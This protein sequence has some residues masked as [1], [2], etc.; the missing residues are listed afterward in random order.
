MNTVFNTPR[1]I[2]CWYLLKL[3]RWG[4]SNRYPQHM[5]LG[6]NK[7]KK[8]FYHLSYWH[9][10]EFF[11]TANSL[12]WQNLGDQCCQYNEVPLCMH[13]DIDGET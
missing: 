5:F 1:D 7:G 3:P 12:L 2:C 8:L 6:V 4:D 13:F 10:L 11:I 9:M